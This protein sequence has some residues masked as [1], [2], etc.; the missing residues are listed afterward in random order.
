MVAA[1]Y[2]AFLVKKEGYA[3]KFRF[4]LQLFLGKIRRPKRRCLRI[5]WIVGK[6]THTAIMFFWVPE[7]FNWLER[8]KSSTRGGLTHYILNTYD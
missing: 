6:N 2:F 5:T 8:L 3:P 7:S 1:I 4:F